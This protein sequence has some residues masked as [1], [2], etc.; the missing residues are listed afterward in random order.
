MNQVNSLCFR[1]GTKMKATGIMYSFLLSWASIAAATTVVIT[2]NPL[3]LHSDVQGYLCLVGLIR[4]GLTYIYIYSK[5][6]YKV[7]QQGFSLSS[8]VEY[9]YARA[10]TIFEMH[11]VVGLY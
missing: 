5:S 6:Y 8:S 7:R 10:E 2:K 9:V 4:A 1:S 3:T 11:Q